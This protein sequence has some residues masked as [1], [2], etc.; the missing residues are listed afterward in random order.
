MVSLTMFAALTMNTWTDN[1]VKQ[2]CLIRSLNE[3]PMLRPDMRESME[4]I[5]DEI[6][7]LRQINVQRG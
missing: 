4:H 6:S 3:I 5:S 2:L 1:I 7:L